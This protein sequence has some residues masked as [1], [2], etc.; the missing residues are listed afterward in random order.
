MVKRITEVS[1]DVEKSKN[2][3]GVSVASAA[4]GTEFVHAAKPAD[5]VYRQEVPRIENN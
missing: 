1:A 5:A 3:D 2:R 4:V